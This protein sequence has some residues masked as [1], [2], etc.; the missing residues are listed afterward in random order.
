M[1]NKKK[2]ENMKITDKFEFIK[3]KPA[4]NRIVMPPMDTLMATDG[5]ANE[6]HIQHY[7]ARSYGGTGTIIIESTAIQENGRIRE[8]DLGLWKDEHIEPFK[9]VVKT[10]K[11]GGA[12]AGIQLNHAGSKAELNMP[13]VGVTKYYSYLDQRQLSIL[14]ISE[15][16][17]IK[18]SF[19]DSARRAKAAGFD[20]VELH[21]AHGYLLSEIISKNVN[22]VTNNPDIL[23]RAK[24]IIDIFDEI[25]QKVQIP[26]GIRFSITDYSDEG[27]KEADFIPLLK[28]LESKA[29]YFHISS[30]EV[31]KRAD[32]PKA[33]KEAGT[34]LFRVP[35]ATKIKEVVSIPV[36][37]VG[38]FISR[39]DAD[40][41]L[42]LGIDAIAIGREQ[43][44]NPNLVVNSLLTSEEI[45]ENLYHWNNNIWFDYKRYKVLKDHL[46]NKKEF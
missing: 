5:F 4:R 23:K 16:E 42:N 29:S 10:I 17:D 34:K 8:K 31:I 37:V 38:N 9:S 15:L 41:A 18:N 30:G 2:E 32:V 1:N 40:Y 39:A 46:I 21:A 28:A 35:L 25:N 6:F 14:T 44:F 22:E 13:T 43:I 36:I 19:V 33:M 3:G 27:M 11:M 20:F 45:D 24:I 26:T 12:L 7:G